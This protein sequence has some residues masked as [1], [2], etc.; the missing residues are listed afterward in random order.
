MS[1][2]SKMIESS[3]SGA[4]VDPHAAA[5]H[6]VA[7]HAAGEDAAAGDDRVDGLAA[8][9]LVVE[10]ELGGRVRV[11]GGAQRP[12][13]VVEVQRRARP[14]AGPCW[15][16][17]RRRWFRRRASRRPRPAGR[18]ESGW[19][20][21]R[22][23]TSSTRPTMRGQDVAAEVVR[24]ALVG[25]V[26]VAVRAAACGSRRCSCPSR[27]RRARDRPGMVGASAFFSWKPMMRPS[28]A[29]SITPNSAANCFG[30]P[31]WRR[32]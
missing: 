12:L 29:A 25:R 21:S 3:T 14:R 19:S 27:R 16:R 17:S 15:P 20:G 8:A 22:R 11:A 24:A 13:P 10:G 1:Q 6:R 31:G 4:G 26:G 30:P 5:E 7:H 32:R 28:G 9:A 2:L 23:R 18:R